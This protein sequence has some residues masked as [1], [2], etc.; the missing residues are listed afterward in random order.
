MARP[1][2]LGTGSRGEVGRGLADE[3]RRVVSRWGGPRLGGAWLTRRGVSRHG[4]ERCGW[5]GQG[6]AVTAR[7]GPVRQAL[8]DLGLVRH[9]EAWRSWRG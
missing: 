1:S 2:W 9:G 4:W 8:A 3:A 7:H 5:V 6:A